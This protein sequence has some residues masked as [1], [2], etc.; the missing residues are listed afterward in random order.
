M[1]MPGEDY[2][3]RTG[4]QADLARVAA[5]ARKGALRQRCEAPAEF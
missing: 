1:I 4:A 5:I 3:R 2:A